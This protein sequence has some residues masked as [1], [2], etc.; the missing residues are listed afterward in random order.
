MKVVFESIFQP[1]VDGLTNAEPKIERFFLQ[2]EVWALKALIFF[3][4]HASLVLKIGEAFL[5]VAGIIGGLVV[6]AI[7]LVVAAMSAPFLLFT[8]LIFTVP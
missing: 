6:A 2:L 3:K 7:G 5:L 1:L 4:P 8:A